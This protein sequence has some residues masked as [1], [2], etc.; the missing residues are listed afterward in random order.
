MKVIKK[1]ET[2][3]NSDIKFYVLYYLSCARVSSLYPSSNKIESILTADLLETNIDAAIDA[4][5]D[6]YR[7]LGGSD[8]VAKGTDYLDKIK[9]KL[10]G[11]YGL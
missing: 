3:E 7:E 4:C 10:K 11:E 8:K 5:Y 2:A 9:E 1:Y 6:I